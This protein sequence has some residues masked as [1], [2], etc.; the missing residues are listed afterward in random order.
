[1]SK[2]YP[3][4]PTQ[5]INILVTAIPEPDPQSGE[6]R[7]T[8][9]FTPDIIRVVLP[10]TVINYQ[11]VSPTPAGVKIDSI[12]IS[13]YN[14]QL[15]APSIGCSGKIATLSDANTRSE[16]LNITLNFIDEV[17]VA[18]AVDPEIRNDPEPTLAR[19]TYPDGATDVCLSLDPEEPNNPEPIKF[20]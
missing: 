13:P 8:T 10:D 20:A 16:T 6:V 3:I 19:S 17:G 12:S 4:T 9:T 2:H 15:S 14:A 1:M 18:F 5:F 11:L 7:Y